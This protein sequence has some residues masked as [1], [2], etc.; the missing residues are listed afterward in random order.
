MGPGVAAPPVA[1]LAVLALV[2][3]QPHVSAR[4]TTGQS[5][6]ESAVLA[7]S[8]WVAN[9]G[10]GTLARIDPGKNRVT[11]RI[12]VGRGACAVTAGAGAVWVANYRT[13]RLLRVDPST[14]KVRR[15][16][17]RGAPFDVLLANGSVW[18]TGFANGTLVRVDAR[19]LR[20]RRR[21][22][23]GGSP[24]GL[25]KAA[26]AIWVGLGRGA[27]NVLRVDSKSG[28]V[29]R[30]DVGATAPDHLVATAAG[31]WAVNDGD[32]LVLLDPATGRALRVKHIG[33]TLVQPALAPDGTLW[34]PDK[35]LDMIFRLD[36][37]TGELRDSFHAGDG[38][39]QVL[40]AFGSMWVT[41]YAGEDIWRYAT[42]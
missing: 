21:I 26:G 41:S 33:R 36:P 14:R 9:D 8:V 10:A 28:S 16:S 42:R 19:T 40:H 22:K 13:G 29:K 1:A 34:V 32:T 5:P 38:A 24:T 35:E 31:I 3:S 17:V 2:G 20:V 39:F 37:T 15:I 18:T 6:C 30:I 12:P 7:G 25:L 11:A 23:V 4:I 27:T